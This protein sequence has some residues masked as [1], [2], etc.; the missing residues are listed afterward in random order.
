MLLCVGQQIYL[1]YRRSLQALPN[2]Q[3]H[4]LKGSLK[5][6]N[7]LVQLIPKQR[8]EEFQGKVISEF[9]KVVQ[10]VFNSRDDPA[11]VQG[12]KMG[13]VL[14]DALDQGQNDR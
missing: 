8:L 3:W 11:T 9:V 6:I 4:F 1:K 7:C 10:R 2:F 14:M 5:V 12:K 13:K